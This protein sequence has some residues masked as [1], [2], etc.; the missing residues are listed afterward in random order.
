MSI[1]CGTEE[2]I[3]PNAWRLRQIEVC[4]RIAD[5]TLTVTKEGGMSEACSTHG[6]DENAYR[7]EVGKPKGNASFRIPR[8]R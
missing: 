4:F 5:F 1:T 8:H 7:N 3:L 2:I 6:T